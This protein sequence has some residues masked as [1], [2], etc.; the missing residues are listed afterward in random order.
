M[1]ASAVTSKDRTESDVALSRDEQWETR[2]ARQVQR[3]YLIERCRGLSDTRRQWVLDRV[4]CWRALRASNDHAV[5][6]RLLLFRRGIQ[7][8]VSP[9]SSTPGP[10][11]G[12]CLWTDLERPRTSTCRTASWACDALGTASRRLRAGITRAVRG[13]VGP[14]RPVWRPRP[15]RGHP[16][17]SLTSAPRVRPSFRKK[18]RPRARRIRD[19]CVC[20]VSSFLASRSI[21][22]GRCTT[23]LRSTATGLTDDRL[24]TSDRLMP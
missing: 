8:N 18:S 17:F 10:W 20:A 15:R 16:T 4:A 19:R 13:K 24:T 21:G 2:G 12:P 5:T 1:C 11:A 7:L 22:S 23:R 6:I 9:Y 3:P 14:G